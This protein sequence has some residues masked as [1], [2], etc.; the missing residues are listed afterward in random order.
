MRMIT[1]NPAQRITVDEALAHPY[2][3]SVRKP[4][5][6]FNA[7]EALV[8]HIEDYDLSVERTQEYV[9]I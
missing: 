3:A 4:A 1:F 7:T 2:L 6:E 9:S 8:M 5:M